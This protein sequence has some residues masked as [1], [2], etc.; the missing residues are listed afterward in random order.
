MALE[1]NYAFDYF[2]FFAIFSVVCIHT[3][4]LEGFSFIGGTDAFFI[5]D[6]FTRFAV[7]FFFMVSGFLIGQKNDLLYLKRYLIN[8]IKNLMTWVLFFFVYDICTNLLIL[9]RSGNS[10][11]ILN[12]LN[13]FFNWKTIIYGPPGTAHH[14]WYLVVLIWSIIIIY[15]AIKIKKNNYLLTISFILNLI[16]VFGQAYSPIFNISLQ[17]RDALFFGL[18]YVLSGYIIGQKHDVVEKNI[19]KISNKIYVLLFAVFSLTSLMEKT[20]IYIF[21]KESTE[22]NYYLSTPLLTFSLFFLALKNRNIGKNSKLAKVGRNSLGIYLTHT[23]FISIVDYTLAILGLVYVTK[24]L[25]WQLIFTPTVFII[26]YLF[27]NII[28]NTILK[29]RNILNYKKEQRIAN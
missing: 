12:F 25:V 22:G 10:R 29:T 15:V 5:I 3:K 6:V 24:L 28:Q 19:K 7:P 16:G 2:K 21:F 4:F 8:T 20:I 1:R 23:L 27:Y 11:N 9:K 26:S 17:T 18:F 13:D 14:L